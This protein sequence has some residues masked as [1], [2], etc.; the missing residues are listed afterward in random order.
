MKPCV[1]ADAG[2]LIGLARI[3]QV[4]LVRSLYE[5]VLIPPGVFEEL[6]IAEGR[7]GALVLSRAITD[8]WLAVGR[9]VLSPDLERLNLLLDPG[10]AEAI[11]LAAQERCRL[12]LI[13]DPRGRKVAQSRGPTISGTGG[14]LLA[15]KRKGLVESV[16][17]ILGS[18]ALSGY[19]LSGELVSRLLQLAGEG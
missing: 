2:P 15:A 11:L 16:G 18:L 3:G 1:V 5:A 4:G 12:L 17:P 8:G 9:L 7:P 6:R 19:R 13:D 10:E 14:V